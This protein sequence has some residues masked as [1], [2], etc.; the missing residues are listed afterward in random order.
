VA[1]DAVGSVYVVDYG[2]NT[3]T[4]LLGP[5]VNRGSVAEAS[6]YPGRK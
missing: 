4:A 1:V 5:T 2:T 6:V 3:Y